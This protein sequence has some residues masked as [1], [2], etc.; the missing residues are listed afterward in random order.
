VTNVPETTLQWTGSAEDPVHLFTSPT[1]AASTC[2]TLL[3]FRTFSQP[4]LYFF[5]L[6]FS[7]SMDSGKD[8]FSKIGRSF[9]QKKFEVHVGPV[10]DELSRRLYADAIACLLI[11][12]PAEHDIAR[13]IDVCFVIVFVAHH[14]VASFIT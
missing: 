11:P 6:L 13:F 2:R 1:R 4:L 12:E 14:T 9:L 8:R 3:R 7:F 10:R 5:G